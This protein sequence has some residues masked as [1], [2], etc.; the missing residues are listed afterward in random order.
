MSVKASVREVG[1]DFLLVGFGLFRKILSVRPSWCFDVDSLNRAYFVCKNSQSI[2]Y[3][4][5]STA[6][7]RRRN[8]FHSEVVEK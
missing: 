2:R 5:C 4:I 7:K 8:N 6:S 3:E 1:V